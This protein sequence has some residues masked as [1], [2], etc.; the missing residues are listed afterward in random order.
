MNCRDQK[1]LQA[2]DSTR[3]GHYGTLP[4][5]RLIP[6]YYESTSLM[7]RKGY[8]KS[9]RGLE[10]QE[11][12]SGGDEGTE[13][14]YSLAKTAIQGFTSLQCLSPRGCYMS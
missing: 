12:K 1:S 14:S 11:K 3:E 4:I 7:S 9:E 13:I 2:F 5:Q 6:K 8:V 10:E